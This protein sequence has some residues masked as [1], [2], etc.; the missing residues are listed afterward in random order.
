MTD[1]DGGGWRQMAADG[2][3]NGGKQWGEEL[4][5]WFYDEILI[6]TYFYSVPV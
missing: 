6:P 5:I 3:G 4:L 1:A 2:G